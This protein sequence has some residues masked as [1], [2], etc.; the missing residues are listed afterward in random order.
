MLLPRLR[1]RRPHD[2]TALVDSRG[3]GA[4]AAKITHLALLPDDRTQ[5]AGGVAPPNDLAAFVDR[6]SLA[7]HVERPDT[8]AAFP[9]SHRKARGRLSLPLLPMTWPRSLT[10]TAPLPAP[11]SVPRSVITHRACTAPADPDAADAGRRARRRPPPA[12]SSGASAPPFTHKLPHT[13]S[14]RI[15]AA[16]DPAY[17]ELPNGQPL[18]SVQRAAWLWPF[19]VVL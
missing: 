6:Q 17:P 8:R 11:P 15:R 10:A 2:L 12:A 4:A 9:F 19:L 14:Q 13:R 3:I 7:F 1:V 16:A 18:R 5:P